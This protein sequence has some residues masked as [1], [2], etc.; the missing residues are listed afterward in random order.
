MLED[1]LTQQIQFTKEYFRL[2]LSN[3]KSLQD[4][5]DKQKLVKTQ[6]NKK[7]KSLNNISKQRIDFAIKMFKNNYD[8][9]AEIVYD[10]I[11]ESLTN[12]NYVYYAN[13]RTEI[14]EYIDTIYILQKDLKVFRNN[15]K[16]NFEKF[17]RTNTYCDLVVLNNFYNKFNA[18][19]NAYTK[20]GVTIDEY[21]NILKEHSYIEAVIE[22]FFLEEAKIIETEVIQ[23]R[24]QKELKL[25]QEQ[26]YLDE[27]NKMFINVDSKKKNQEQ[28]V[29]QILLGMKL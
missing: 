27:I 21:K 6:A 20:M 4:F 2:R 19:I 3:E 18:D 23:Y 7:L 26:M 5:K 10:F 24:E 12:S 28:E 14:I 16:K 13:K 29:M 9:S 17:K 1:K 25:K 15:L 11:I 22:E 8:K